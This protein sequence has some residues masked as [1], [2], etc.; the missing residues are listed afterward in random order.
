LPAGAEEK[1]DDDT[2]WDAILVDGWGPLVRHAVVER[3]ERATVGAR[4]TLV[5]AVADPEHARFAWTEWLHEQVVEAIRLETGADL[6]RLGSQAA[7]AC[8]EES[9]DLLAARWSDGGTMGV[10]S[11]GT[12]RRVRLLLAAAPLWLAERAG[13]DV[14]AVPPEPLVL[15]GATRVDVEG[16]ADCLGRAGLDR[17]TRGIALALIGCV[18]SAARG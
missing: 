12:E 11:P 4:G 2:G 17:R 14:S 16:I 9:W 10:V 1:V 3:V 5:R 7:W 8:Y 18:R 6:D 15:A 13:A